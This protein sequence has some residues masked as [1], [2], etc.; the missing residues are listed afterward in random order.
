MS[1]ASEQAKQ[2]TAQAQQDKYMAILDKVQDPQAAIR[3]G[4]PASVVTEYYKAKDLG[5]SEVGRTV[6]VEGPGGVKMIQQLDKFGAPIGQLMPGYMP[7]QAVNTGNAV[8]FAKPVQGQSFD[9]NMSPGD[10]ARLAQSANQFQQ[11]QANRPERMVSVLGPNG[12]AI[13]VPQSQSQG[14]PLYNPQAAASL[15]KEKT[16]GQAKEQLSGVVQQLNNSYTA[17][18]QGGGITSTA[19]GGLSNLGARL[20]STGF[21]QAVGGALGTANQRQRQEIEQTRPLLLNLIK[22]ATG[23]TASQMNSN[24]E[25]QLYLKAATDPTLTVEANRSALANLDKMFGLGIAKPPADA[26]KTPA[27]GANPQ[28]A[29]ALKWAR[30]NPNDPRS[31]TILQRLGQ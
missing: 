18:E 1:L 19:Q 20:G 6:E 11:S 8:T 27:G 21:G 15:Q 3:A 14:L 2:R 5:R 24:A 10:K 22:D 31:K 12:E 28:D 26:A 29:E 30:S 25:M 9:V 17:L 16:K 13:T 4:V 23:M 7:A